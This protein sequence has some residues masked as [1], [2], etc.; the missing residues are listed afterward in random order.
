MH[1][2]QG[3]AACQH[4]A[5]SHASSL[6]H[7]NQD[8]GPQRPPEISRFLKNIF[9][10]RW[11]NFDLISSLFHKWLTIRSCKFLI[12]QFYQVKQSERL[13]FQEVINTIGVYI[14]WFILTSPLLREPLNFIYV[15]IAFFKFFA[16]FPSPFSPF[17]FPPDGGRKIFDEIYTPKLSTVLV[18]WLWYRVGAI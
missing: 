7:A 17:L 18:L 5:T 1:S 14:L 9:S 11:D 2:V 8:T 6:S 12:S 13:H 16:T 3:S 15:V 10:S 4:A